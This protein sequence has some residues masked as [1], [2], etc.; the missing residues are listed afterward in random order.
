ML[1]PTHLST[2]PPALLLGPIWEFVEGMDSLLGRRVLTQH[3]NEL[4]TLLEVLP[5]SQCHSWALTH[6]RSPDLD[7]N[8]TSVH[9]CFSL[10]GPCGW[11]WQ[12][13]LSR[14]PILNSKK[15]ILPMRVM[16]SE[17]IKIQLTNGACNLGGHYANG[18]A[19]SYLT[20][21]VWVQVPHSLLQPL[22]CPDSSG[23][24]SF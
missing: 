24:I 6:I 10:S 16:P 19:H 21:E 8:V 2:S 15:A 18:F 11:N 13:Y 3:V 22:H 12:H 17:T 4:H 1:L 20:L 9:L 7:K 14:I 23:F 5:S